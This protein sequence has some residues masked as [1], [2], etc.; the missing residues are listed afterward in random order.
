MDKSCQ[1]T[2]LTMEKGCHTTE[3]LAEEQMALLAKS[4]WLRALLDKFMCYQVRA[5][6][7][8]GLIVALPPGSENA[9]RYLSSLDT[10]REKITCQWKEKETLWRKVGE[11]TGHLMKFIRESDDTFC[12]ENSDIVNETY[13]N[14]MA[15]FDEMAESRYWTYENPVEKL[16]TDS[17]RTK[18]RIISSTP[19]GPTK[20]TENSSSSLSGTSS[21]SLD[22]SATNSDSE[23]VS[24][25]A[26]L[27]ISEK[28]KKPHKKKSKK[29]QYDKFNNSVLI[30]PKEVVKP[31]VFDM[32][33]VE[34]FPRFL[35][36]YERYFD[37]KFTGTSRDCTRE[38][39]NFLP[40]D[41]R[42]VYKDIGGANLDYEI[43]KEGLLKW[44]KANKNKN[45]RYWRRLLLEARMEPQETLVMYG[46]RLKQ[47]ALKAYPN[48][49][50]ECVRELKHQ[51]CSTVPEW[52]KIK[53]ET[54]EDLREQI[55][56]HKLSWKDRMK[57]AEKEDKRKS[58]R[59]EVKEVKYGS[60]SVVPPDFSQ[61]VWFS[62]GAAVG[63]KPMKEGSKK[64]MYKP[65]VSHPARE[66]QK[67]K[68]RTFVSSG[69]GT[70]RNQKF[71][72]WCGRNGH[73]EAECWK[74]NGYCLICGS[75][76]HKLP[77]C[78]KFRRKSPELHCPLC[79]GAH[80]GKDCPAYLK[81]S[82]KTDERQENLN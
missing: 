81:L 62:S 68:P 4:Q 51:F 58:T 17:V 9:S 78:P 28:N 41:M 45:S 3:L 64:K 5:D 67:H 14:W 73:L 59:K 10:I 35:N 71:C 18:T 20:A 44:Y 69:V 6:F 30:Y 33:G 36:N 40:E 55:G 53:M 75:M 23:G 25:L 52:F 63:P 61:P 12:P 74:K 22:E 19:I 38:L 56:K 15:L 8:N 49:D 82:E 66:V 7:V 70:Q 43:M 77:D 32:N 26:S 2:V 46:M 27:K 65:N 48:S 57:L 54:M 80:L 11:S 16:K 42:Y 47:Y 34:S 1:A 76:N 39:F 31:S 21:T 24:S 72:L 79:D 13:R 50:R 37:N 29:R 60:A